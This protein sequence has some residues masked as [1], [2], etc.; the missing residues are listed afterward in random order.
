MVDFPCQRLTR[1]GDLFESGQQQHV[2]KSEDSCGGGRFTRGGRKVL[3]LNVFLGHH[4]NSFKSLLDA[5]LLFLFLFPVKVFGSFFV[6]WFCSSLSKAFT[7]RQDRFDS[8]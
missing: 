1:T 4:E 2:G 7:L 5:L 8:L 6:L 3:M